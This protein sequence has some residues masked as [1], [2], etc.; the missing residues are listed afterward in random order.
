MLKYVVADGAYGRKTC[1]LIVREFGLELI[2]KLNRN[3]AL[4]LPYQGEYSGRVVTI[5]SH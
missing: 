1:C 2:S 4:Y 3:T 5:F